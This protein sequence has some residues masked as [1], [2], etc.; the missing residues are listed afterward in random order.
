M[1]F[2]QDFASSGNILMAG[3]G[4]FQYNF[5]ALPSEST[6]DLL[7]RYDTWPCWP[8]GGTLEA[9]YALGTKPVSMPLQ[10]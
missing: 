3:C 10:S 4:D 8:W 2:H 5:L 7:A 6:T 1:I 9:A